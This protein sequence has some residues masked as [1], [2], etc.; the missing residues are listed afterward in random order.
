[1]D[2]GIKKQFSQPCAELNK[3]TAYKLPY[4]IH[5]VQPNIIVSGKNSHLG[6]LYEVMPH[7]TPSDVNVAFITNISLGDK[8]P[9]SQHRDSNLRPH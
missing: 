1:M 4:P 3:T 9:I 8:V 6:R 5:L 7:V 2:Y